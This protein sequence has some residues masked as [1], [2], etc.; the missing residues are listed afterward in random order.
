MPEGAPVPEA[1][2]EQAPQGPE[3][4]GGPQGGAEQQLQQLAGQLVQT[5]MQQIGD[6]QAVTAILQMALEM[7]GQASQEQAPAYQRRG[8]KLVRVR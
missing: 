6:P 5:L 3:A 2:A 7:V 4:Q 1:G 8:G